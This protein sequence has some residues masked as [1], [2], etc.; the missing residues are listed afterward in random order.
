MKT[1]TKQIIID[2]NALIAIGEFKID[3]FSELHRICD[4]PYAIAILL[5]TIEELNRI[6]QEANGKYKAAAKLALDIIKKKN[7]TIIEEEG[8]VDNLLVQYSQK[9]SIIL[10]QDIELKKRLTKPYLTIRQKKTIIF[11]K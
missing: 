9:G 3:L 10:T 1:E 7:I 4:F 8:Y 5:G 11:I 2:T 6:Y